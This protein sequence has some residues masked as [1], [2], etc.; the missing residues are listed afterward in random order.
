MFYG[1]ITE[2]C[3]AAFVPATQP[4]PPVGISPLEDECESLCSSEESECSSSDEHDDS[5]GPLFGAKKEVPFLAT[6]SAP[7]EGVLSGLQVVQ[8]PDISPTAFKIMVDYIYSNF[9]VKGVAINDDNVM[10]TLYAGKCPIINK[11]IN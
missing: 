1:A 3:V 2:R 9:D 11:P 8:V 7:G 4:P 6:V 10:H 5:E